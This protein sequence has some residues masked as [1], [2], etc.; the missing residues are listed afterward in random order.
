MG[1]RDNKLNIEVARD[2]K[3]IAAESK[4][5]SSSMKTIAVLTIVFLPGTFVSVNCLG[6]LG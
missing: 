5:D 3:S 6:S 4:R 2:S 1:Q